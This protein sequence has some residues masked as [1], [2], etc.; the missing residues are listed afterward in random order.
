MGKLEG[1]R[2]LGEPRRR[3][4]DNIKNGS[5][6]SGMGG[7]GWIDLAQDRDRWRAVVNVVMNL[8]VPYNARNLLTTCNLL[9][10]Q[11][12]LCSMELVLPVV[13]PPHVQKTQ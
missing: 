9:G 8:Q 4:E 1:R 6:R 2:Q 10:S 11:E 12:G 3:W 7:T 13:H 5:S